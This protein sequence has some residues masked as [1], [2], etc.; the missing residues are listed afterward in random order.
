MRFIVR[1]LG[2]VCVGLFV[3]GARASAPVPDADAD[4]VPP[5]TLESD[6]HLF[7]IQRD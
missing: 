3:S 2:V 6:I 4:D 1:L 5:V 7:V